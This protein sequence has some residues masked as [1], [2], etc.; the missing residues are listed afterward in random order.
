[1]KTIEPPRHELTAAAAAVRAAI[2]RGAEPEDLA[3]AALVAAA[4]AG[5]PTIPNALSIDDLARRLFPKVGEIVYLANLDDDR[6]VPA[7]IAEADVEE[8]GCRFR[9]EH[10]DAPGVKLKG[11]G[12]VKWFAGE[13]VYATAQHAH[14]ALAMQAEDFRQS[15]EESA[16]DYQR[17]RDK[18]LAAAEDLTS[19][20]AEHEPVL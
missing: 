4:S 19:L 12:H 7:R 16:L 15:I 1:M 10:P 6:I 20:E 2:E 3:R 9:L 13:N 11:Y 17:S 18:H 8:Y 5:A 14:H